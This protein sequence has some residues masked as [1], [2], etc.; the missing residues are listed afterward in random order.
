MAPTPVEKRAV[1]L[2]AAVFAAVAATSAHLPVT[3]TNAQAQAAIDR[4]VFLY[5]A[6]DGTDATKAF[7]RAA[8]LDP[9]LAMAYWGIALAKGPDLNTPIT[10]ELFD[11]AATAVRKAVALDASASERERRFI[12]IMAL[13]YQGKFA[14]W[15]SDN[16]A[17]RQA[18][19][20]FAETSQDENAK[21]LAAEAL[22]E[23]GGLAWENGAL[24]SEDSRNALALVTAVLHDDP[25]SAMANHLCIHLYDL[26]TDRTPALVCAQRLDAAVFPPE[27]EH[28]A[29]MPAHYW[30]ETGEYA[31]AEASSER[32]Y[33]LM[34]QLDGG[35][36]SPH[37][38]QYAK[39]DVAVGYSAAMMLG[40]YENAQTWSHR[41]ASVFGTG[42]DAFT[43]LRFGHY[44]EAYATGGSQFGGSS[45][46]GLAG[47][48]LGRVS[49][50]R[51]LAARVP[52]TSFAEGY[53]PQ[54]FQARL[55]EADGKYDEAEQWIEKSLQNQ[56]SNLQGELIPLLPAGEALGDLRLRR[57]DSAGAIAA[58]TQTLDAYPNDPRAL[59]G[60]ARALRADGSSTQSQAVRSRFEEAW[61]GADTNA[62]DALL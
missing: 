15:T 20:A 49:E 47:L 56:R 44:A 61:K 21:L 55:A 43:A 2:L 59:L 5:Y 32:A 60:L 7:T 57:G 50:A 17:Y 38:Q 46:R 11:E 3:T 4:G 45:V 29:H 13:R 40:N 18:M 19:F 8:G 12:A 34:T 54:L 24:G 51:A 6:Y 39:H 22:L 16:A 36:E 41:M 9:Q 48:H 14:D 30:I 58:F 25:T 37:A 53:I 31:K 1:T 28:L 42:F 10:Q 33:T 62:S 27:A 26:A 23:A 35:L 52:V